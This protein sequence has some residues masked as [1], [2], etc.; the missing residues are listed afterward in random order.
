MEKPGAGIYWIV[1]IALLL[2]TRVLAD[3][4]YLTID[5]VNLAFA[6]EWFDPLHHQPQ[7]PGYPLFVV[8]AR[9]VNFFSPGVE[10][11]FLFISVLATGLCLPLITALGTRMF[12]IWSGRA[13]ALLLL[14]TPTFWHTGADSPLRPFL[15]LFSLLTAYWSWRCWNGEGR[16]A[17]WAACALGVGSGFRPE[18]LAYLLPMWLIS[19]WAGT[20]S[21]KTVAAG[22]GV[23]GAIVLA[24]TGGLIVAVG[25][26][27]P[28]TSLLSGYLVE[29]AQ[30]ESPI[31]GA[32]LRAWLR[33]MSR[34]VVWNGIAVVWWIWTVPV[35][36]RERQR[37][38]VDRQ[39][40]LFITAWL[41]PG[42]LQQ[43][44]VH[45]AAPGHTLFSVPALCLLGAHMLFIA[46]RRLSSS[47]ASF[48]QAREVMLSAALIFNVMTFL[49]FF[50]V[51]D[52]DASPGGGPSIKNA[53][54]FATLE[55]SL[56]SIRSMDEV[57][58]GTLKE[59][60]QRTPG[61]RP[62][63]II[64]TD[65]HSGEW[66]M[67]WR[68]L[69][70]YEGSRDIWVLTDQ[71]TP[72]TALRVRRYQSLEFLTGTPGIPVPRG[73]RILWILDRTSP[74]NKEL[75]ANTP[76]NAGR[77]VSYTDIPAEAVPF[78]VRGFEFVPR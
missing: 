38:D 33:Q 23:M 10:W 20:R 74:F 58:F 54:A 55:T 76:L 14:V 42:L 9:A 78:T 32:G 31:M 66:F 73:G 72:I 11:T 27:Q 28:L 35:V 65:V 12:S 63:M 44:V 19:A 37:G 70:Y 25:G 46:A 39:A 17:I 4:Y 64:T 5:N 26:V 67:N 1:T 69:R 61:D 62:S 29:Q 2:L 3:A 8:F 16:Y 21:L 49:N 53:V 47:E 68:M 50:P 15:A 41:A 59:L 60:R 34:L 77:Y 18:L 43:A 52:P 56:G 75:A 48:V 30:A 40:L 51:P 24:W 13:A 57:A 22:L 45:V 71:T 6:L 7:P 36:L